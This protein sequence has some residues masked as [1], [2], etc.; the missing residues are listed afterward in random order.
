MPYPFTAR[1]KSALIDQLALTLEEKRIV[2][3]KPGLWPEGIDELEAF[4]YSVT[5]RGNVRTGAPAGCHDD[6]V[7]ALALALWQRRPG[8]PG[9]VVHEIY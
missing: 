1:S 5:D 9:G 4:E 2:L 3:P 6:I 8:R 7:C